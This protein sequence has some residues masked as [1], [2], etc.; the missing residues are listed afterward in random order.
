MR[1]MRTRI[2]GTPVDLWVVNTGVS[3]GQRWAGSRA[4]R[5]RRAGSGHIPDHNVWTAPHTPDGLLRV[6]CAL[7]R[8]LGR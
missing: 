5:P 3:D 7:R 2:A 1:R 4:R 8:E 6:L